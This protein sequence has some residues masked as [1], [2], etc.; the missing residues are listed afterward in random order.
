M[1]TCIIL[2]AHTPV[3]RTFLLYAD[4]VITAGIPRIPVE[5]QDRPV[6]GLHPTRRQRIPVEHIPVGV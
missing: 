3:E 2:L 4:R 6:P 1:N 5:H